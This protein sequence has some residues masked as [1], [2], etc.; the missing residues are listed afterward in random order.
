MDKNPLTWGL[1]VTKK[2]NQAVIMQICDHIS[3]NSAEGNLLDGSAKS[4]LAD[5][6]L[7]LWFTRYT[8]A[9]L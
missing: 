4:I 9:R 3:Q 7:S 1:A 2:W 8:R 6:A 5:T